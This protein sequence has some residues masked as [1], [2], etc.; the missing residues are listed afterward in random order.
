MTEHLAS[1]FLRS[2]ERFP[3]RPAV[4]SAGGEVP[5]SELRDRAAAI[6]AT[7]QGR[8]AAPA[9]RKAGDPPLTAVLA[10]RGPLAIEGILGA[11]LSGHGYVPLSPA[12]L[13]PL[14][15]STR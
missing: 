11:L 3:A 15:S 5:Y 7:L 14:G 4:V 8:R 1:G 13:A 9:A 12:R 2:A 10:E 6:A